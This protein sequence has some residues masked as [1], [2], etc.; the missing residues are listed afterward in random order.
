M[1]ILQN[2]QQLEWKK[3]TKATLALRIQCLEYE[4]SF[5][6]RQKTSEE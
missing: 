6:R 4:L 2:I 3:I 1:K 5:N